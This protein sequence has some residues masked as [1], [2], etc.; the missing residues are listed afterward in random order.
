MQPQEENFKGYGNSA[1]VRIWIEPYRN[2]SLCLFQGSLQTR[3]LRPQFHSGILLSKGAKMSTLSNQEGKSDDHGNKV[4]PCII[5][6][7]GG[8][9]LGFLSSLILLQRNSNWWDHKTLKDR[10]WKKWTRGMSITGSNSNEDILAI[11]VATFS[12]SSEICF[13]N[14]ASSV[15]CRLISASC[16]KNGVKS[17][18]FV[19][20]RIE[21]LKALRLDDKEQ[22]KGK[23]TI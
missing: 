9:S 16:K 11:G 23:T 13:F 8:G 21:W 19:G 18:L 2:V 22:E 10:F 20:R 6:L 3:Y 17:W 15:T 4:Y 12:S 5:A 14:L 1:E 7:V